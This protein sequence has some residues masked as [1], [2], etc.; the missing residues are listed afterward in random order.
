MLIWA[1]LLLTAARQA[2][3]LRAGWVREVPVPIL[4]KEC[5][6]SQW[7]GDLGSGETQAFW[8]Y[9]NGDKNRSGLLM[10][11]KITAV[12]L[13][14]QPFCCSPHRG[15]DDD[16]NCSSRRLPL[17]L[18][19]ASEVPRPSGSA[20]CPLFYWLLLDTII[21]LALTPLIT[22][23]WCFRLKVASWAELRLYLEMTL[24]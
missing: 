13:T 14:W 7:R 21:L 22:A 16:K 23:V 15:H 5:H 17:T 19:L 8:Y 9:F 1:S 6:L 3:D 2:G 10:G 18:F 11:W 20:L 12:L 4:C 24:G